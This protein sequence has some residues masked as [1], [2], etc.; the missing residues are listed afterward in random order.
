MIILTSC[1]GSNSS[2]SFVGTASNAAIFIQWT[3]N[4]NQ[5][6]GELQQAIAQTDNTSSTPGS[7]SISNENL[8]FTGTISGSSVTLSLNQPLGAVTNLN[9]ARCTAASSP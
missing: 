4:G 5:L 2:S 9:G 6:T 1:G 7:Q 3:R 8:A